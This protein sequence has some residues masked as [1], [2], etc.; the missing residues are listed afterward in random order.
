MSGRASAECELAQARLPRQ[1][2]SVIAD[3]QQ[4]RRPLGQ[5]CTVATARLRPGEVSK[6]LSACM[7][8]L[9][10]RLPQAREQ[11]TS[12][13]AF[14]VRL[15]HFTVD[16]GVSERAAFPSH[17]LQL[18]GAQTHIRPSGGPYSSQRRWSLGCDTTVAFRGRLGRIQKRVEKQ[19]NG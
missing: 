14:A 19:E 12:R 17:V 3:R 5:L 6:V 16:G 9:H 1:S 4:E 10:S 11:K 7:L 13:T 18:L 15:A 2:F 8:R